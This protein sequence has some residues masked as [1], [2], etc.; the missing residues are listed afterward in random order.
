MV[1]VRARPPS[2]RRYFWL[3]CSDPETG[4]PY[5]IFGGNNEDEARQ[6]GIECLP[7]IDFQI[8]GLPTRNLAMASSM[9]RGK[10]LEETRSLTQAKKRLGHQKSLDRLQ[11]RRQRRQNKYSNR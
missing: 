3:I 7:G 1:R 10:R 4:Q 5:L 6:R 9:V 2:R 11:R 8:R